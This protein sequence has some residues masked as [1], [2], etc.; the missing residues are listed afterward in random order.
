MWKVMRRHSQSRDNPKIQWLQ[1][2]KCVTGGKTWGGSSAEVLVPPW[3][4]L[5][6]LRTRNLLHC[7]QLSPASI[8]GCKITS[9]E[10][11]QRAQKVCSHLESRLQ[12]M[13]HFPLKY[14]FSPT[15]L[16]PTVLL[17]D[18][19][20]PETCVHPGLPELSF[21]LFIRFFNDEMWQLDQIISKFPSNSLVLIS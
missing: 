10:S 1:R 6:C 5:T 20:A 9:I 17:M 13:H 4:E 7:C 15:L 18:C 3:T 14:K 19:L 8:R 2:N 16:F 12:T 21:L 11:S